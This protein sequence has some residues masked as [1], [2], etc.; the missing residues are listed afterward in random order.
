VVFLEGRVAKPFARKLARLLH[1]FANERPFSIIGLR[2]EMKCPSSS[3]IWSS[4][5]PGL[6]RRIS[7][8]M[9]HRP[10]AIQTGRP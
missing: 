6:Q 10:L 3:G 7:L 5:P 2:G 9:S 1:E 8:P 4:S